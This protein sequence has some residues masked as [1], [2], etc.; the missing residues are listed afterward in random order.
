MTIHSN[1]ISRFEHPPASNSSG[2]QII[3]AGFILIL[4]SFFILLTSFTSLQESKITRFAK[5]FSTEVSVFKKGR[6]V[7]KENVN[8]N[9][10]PDLMD[11]EN[12]IALLFEKVNALGTAYHLD[13]VDIRTTDR[14]VVMTL[15]ETMLF[16][17]G[18]ALLSNRALPLLKKIGKVIGKIG[19]PVEI[20]G[21]TDDRP[22]QNRRY[23]SNW[24]L[25]TARA[26]NVL[27]YLIQNSEV[28]PRQISAAGRSEFHPL[29]PNISDENMAANR[30]VEFIFGVD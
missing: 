23:A 10:E 1:H 5:S 26:I 18:D 11:R 8:H 14:G 27:R 16:A 20:E 6:S 2:W 29:V 28:P 4:L 19:V 24:Y 15:S 22:I 17:S 7:F 13:G 21:H 25:S 30:R 3:Y 12:R 9:G